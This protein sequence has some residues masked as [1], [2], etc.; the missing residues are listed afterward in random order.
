M[1]TDSPW[2]I[3]LGLLFLVVA[4]IATQYQGAI[5]MF[6]FTAAALTFVLYF[7]TRRVVLAIASA[8]ED[9]TMPLKGTGRDVFVRLVNALERAKLDLEAG[10]SPQAAES[11]PSQ[12]VGHRSGR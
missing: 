7:A 10:T 3:A 8:G 5:A 9:I 4:A 6:M 11:G 2:L 12:A 1:T